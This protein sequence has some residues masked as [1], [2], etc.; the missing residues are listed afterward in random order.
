[1]ERVEHKENVNEEIKE[2][3]IKVEHETLD[4]VKEEE[5]SDEP[6]ALSLLK[7]FE[8][9]L[10][11][12]KSKL[13]KYHLDISPELKNYY[14]LLCKNKPELFGDFEKTFNNIIS[15]DKLNYDDIPELI[16]LIKKTYDGIISINEYPTHDIY[17]TIK[18]FLYLSVVVYIEFKNI[19]NK[20]T[21]NSLMLII[22]SAID[23][24]QLIP[25]KG[26]KS[27]VFGCC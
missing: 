4:D 27:C 11:D 1:M 25:F 24:I 20:D 17:E 10:T 18:L 5:K 3:D 21:L 14:M 13:S 15:D 8:L 16:T 9:F 23:L 12:E 2:T 7:L 22:D 6:V 19:K 26:K